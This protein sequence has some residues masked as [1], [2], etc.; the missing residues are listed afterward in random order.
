MVLAI[1]FGVLVGGALAFMGGGGSILAIPLLAYGLGLDPKQAM[2][3]SLVVVGLAALTA[4]TRNW[5]AGLVDGRIALTFGLLGTVG[6]A[7]GAQIARILSPSSQM[8]LFGLTM[9]VAAVAILRRPSVDTPQP[10]SSPTG[11]SIPAA[12]AALVV[13][14][15]SGI[16]GI[17]GGFIVVPVLVSVVGLPIHRAIGT[18]LLIIVFHAIGG[19]LSYASYVS[20]VTPVLFPFMLAA[21]VSA[22]VGARLARGLGEFRLRSVFAV[23]LIIL[24]VFTIVKEVAF[25]W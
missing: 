10:A 19:V 1:V 25:G 5:K 22:S 9:V 2:S 14:S 3:T 12:M 20:I 17:G 21:M 18:S 4:A 16:V 8:G 13:G 23:G 6:S 7:L 15:I 11:L 24:G